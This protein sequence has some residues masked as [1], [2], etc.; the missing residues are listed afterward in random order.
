MVWMEALRWRS[1]CRNG[2]TA[3]STMVAFMASFFLAPASRRLSGGHLALHFVSR[4]PCAGSAP[5][6]DAL[7]TAGG[8]PVLQIPPRL[9]SGVMFLIHILQP[10]QRQVG[11]H[12][13]CRN[14][15]VAEDGLHGAQVSTIF[16]H[17]SSAT[18][19]QHVRA[20]I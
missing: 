19:A 7:A 11:V 1:D 13:R 14:V 10:V 20:G 12:L 17:M 3:F 2:A 18:V 5:R 9:R 8:T 16:H 6:G 15:S 4:W